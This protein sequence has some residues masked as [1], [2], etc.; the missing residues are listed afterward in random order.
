MRKVTLSQFLWA[1]LA[2]LVVSALIGV[3]LAGVA[4]PA[5]GAA[6]VAAKAAP[7]SFDDIPAELEIVVPAEESRMVDADGKLIARFYSYKRVIV[8][9]DQIAPV[10][11]EAI[12]SIEDKKF[13]NHHGVDPERML[14]SMV[15]NLNSSSTQGAS[16][17]TQQY[18]KNMLLE[19]GLQEG[20]Q[21]LIDEAQAQT[22]ER[23]L[24]EARYAISLE[25]K[26]SKDDIL[27]GYLNVAAFGP[28]VYGVEAAART[29]F[30]VGAQDLNLSQAALLA[31]LVQD[32]V[33]DDPFTHPEAAQERRNMVL[34]EMKKDGIINQEEYDEATAISVEDMLKP[35]ARTE[36]CRG[37]G[38]MA[39][40]CDFALDQFLNDETFGD[41]YAERLHLLK[42]GGLVIR[43]TIN[44]E[45]QARAQAA[46]EARVPKD[47]PDGLNSA[48]VSVVPQNGYVVAMAQNTDYD[49][50]EV[51]F[52]TYSGGGNGFQPGSTFKVFTLL[53]WFKEGHSAYESVGSSNRSYPVGSFTCNGEVFPAS[54]PSVG[55]LAGKDGPQTVMRATELSINQAY[56]SMASKV[57]YCKIFSGAA[58][59]GVVRSDGTPFP[60]DNPSQIIGGDDGV[61]PLLMASAFATFANKGVRCAPMGVTS[62]ADRDGKALK[63]YE[64]SCQQVIDPTVAAQ[65]ATV[66]KQTAESYGMPIGRE[67]AAKTGTTDNNSNTWMVGF[68]PQLATAGW[69]GFASDSA[70]AVQDIWI[71]DQY[72]DVVYGGTFIGPMW[73]QYMGSAAEVGGYGD[74]VPLTTTYVGSAAPAPTTTAPETNNTQPTN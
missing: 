24:R 41:T 18:V 33:D 38:S 15:N 46:V 27:T 56:V 42:T 68:T 4:V 37:A 71:G 70:R 19:K 2:F 1:A 59:L 28:T 58:D 30:S 9:G 8:P 7:A 52:N 14:G 6:G 21:D 67:Y 10:M 66:L 62:V 65:V 12:V 31:G 39:Y 16:T 43:T 54:Y 50:T 36:G 48:L 17:I 72:F 22:V 57:D 60:P 5:V 32:P 64:P 25:T 49:N 34:G 55:D 26:M 69:A 63:E 45:L 3:L 29:Y 73:T 53:E 74:P 35:N 11:R 44:Q 13:Y 40:F 51:S 20:D 23:K 61:A 47:Q